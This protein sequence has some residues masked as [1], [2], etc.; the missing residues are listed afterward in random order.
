MK[1]WME[2]L[3]ALM[4]LGGIKKDIALLAVSGA[5][6][7]CSL[8]HFRPFG[9]DMAWIAIVL[10]GLPITFPSGRSAGVADRRP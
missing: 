1:K 2:R 9:F 10:C 8:L 4:E 7:A 5:A 6:I 3:E